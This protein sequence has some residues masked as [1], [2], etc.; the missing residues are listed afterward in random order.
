[1]REVGWGGVES[2]EGGVE[3]G[4]KWASLVTYNRLCELRRLTLCA[5][6]LAWGSAK[7]TITNNTSICPPYLILI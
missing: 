4:K 3:R 7:I 5:Q 1:M 6:G 2:R